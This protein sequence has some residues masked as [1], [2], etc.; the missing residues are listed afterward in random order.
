MA[1][2]SIV[3]NEQ[4]LLI[5]EALLENN[6]DRYKEVWLLSDSQ[7]RLPAFVS[8]AIYNLPRPLRNFG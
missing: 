8:A 7:L 5:A 1:V 2:L 6:N 4:R 3:M